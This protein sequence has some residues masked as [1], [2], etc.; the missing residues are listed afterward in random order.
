MP[1]VGRAQNGIWLYK[2][3]SEGKLYLSYHQRDWKGARKLP[4]KVINILISNGKSVPDFVP[5]EFRHEFY[6]IGLEENKSKF[7]K[8]QQSFET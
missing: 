2:K 3:N 7:N 1:T 5:V 6:V 8:F 4:N